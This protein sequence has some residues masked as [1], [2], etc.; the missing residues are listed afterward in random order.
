[1]IIWL[2]SL[3]VLIFTNNTRFTAYL[4][5]V[6]LLKQII[7][8]AWRLMRK[9]IDWWQIKTINKVA[10][11][12]S[13]SLFIQLKWCDINR[14]MVLACI[15]LL[16]FSSLCFFEL[17]LPTD[18]EQNFGILFPSSLFCLLFTKHLLLFLRISHYF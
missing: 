3:F 18:T 5:T 10:D 6:L 2:I 16:W 11:R 9:L 8:A 17:I 1:M 4:W 7:Y 15:K 14:E 12:L 13:E